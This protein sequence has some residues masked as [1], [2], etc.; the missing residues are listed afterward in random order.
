MKTIMS[1]FS[2]LLLSMAG[3]PQ[4][5][6]PRD[7]SNYWNYSINFI[8][9]APGSQ[10]PVWENIFPSGG[11]TLNHIRYDSNGVVTQ[12][13]E[14]WT[15]NGGKLIV[16]NVIQSDKVFYDRSLTHDSVSG[17]GLDV[18]SV[19]VYTK[20]VFGNTYKV[21]KW[22]RF[23][24]VMDNTY[25]DVFE[26]AETFGVIYREKLYGYPDGDEFKFN[27]ESC[28]VRD[29]VYGNIDSFVYSIY[30]N[31]L[32]QG[33][34]IKIK[35]ITKN[36]DYYKLR[37]K[38]ESPPLYITIQDSILFSTGFLNWVVN[39]P[40]SLGNCKFVLTSMSDS[41]VSGAS[42]GYF[43]VYSPAQV[44]GK[45]EPGEL[46]FNLTQNYPNPF[47]PITTI[48]Y[49]IPCP[50]KVTIKV[51]GIPGNLTETLVNEDKPAGTYQVTWN[52][53]NMPSGIY[54]YQIKAGS[55][56]ETKKMVLLK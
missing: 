22:Y 27:L 53:V 24:R 9:Y 31:T 21:Q 13:E 38:S 42:A 17:S 35:F 26:T 20:P 16:E 37:L 34:E 47:N 39:T 11:F 33:E 55:F 23:L 48:I 54:F 28:C 43:Q 52:A 5:I 15:E 51:Y 29:T 1:M 56:I 25:R 10:C 3:Y 14:T 12:F 46:K 6:V 4:E 45:E 30:R 41:S 40:Q 18:C 36:Q 50:G 19:F 32:H 2:L 7:V 8:P 49:S 44:T